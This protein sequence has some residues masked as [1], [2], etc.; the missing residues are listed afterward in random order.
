MYEKV[1]SSFLWKDFKLVLEPLNVFKWYFEEKSFYKYLTV[2]AVFSLKWLSSNHL[3]Q[4]HCLFQHFWSSCDITYCHHSP[5]VNHVWPC[6]FGLQLLQKCCKFCFPNNLLIEVMNNLKKISPLVI[7]NWQ[8][9]YI[10]VILVV[11][12]FIWQNFHLDCTD[13]WFPSECMLGPKT[14]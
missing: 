6:A 8:R 5:S 14:S 11:F 2:T 13:T 7:F 4:R 3:F 1:W 9:L 12:H 10:L